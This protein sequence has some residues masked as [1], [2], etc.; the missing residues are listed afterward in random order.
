MELALPLTLLLI[1]MAIA[2]AFFQMRGLNQ[3]VTLL[4]RQHLALVEELGK[5]IY[6]K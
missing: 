3:R 1:V 4:E 2:W 6:S 5:Q